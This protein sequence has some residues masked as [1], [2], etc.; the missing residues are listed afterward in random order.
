MEKPSTLTQSGKELSTGN[1]N[2]AAVPPPQGMLYVAIPEGRGLRPSVDPY[3]VCQFQ[4]S[5]YISEGPR[6]KYLDSKT[7]DSKTEDCNGSKPRPMAIPIRSR[8]N[9]NSSHSSDPKKHGKQVTDPKWKHEAVL[10][11][12]PPCPA[13][14][15]R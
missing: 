11:V 14:L 13:L 12:F 8:Q 9:S 5:E 4:R 10:Y 2:G 15:L 7:E 1:A 6:D 3:V